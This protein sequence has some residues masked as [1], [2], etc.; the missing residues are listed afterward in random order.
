MRWN[1]RVPVFVFILLTSAFATI[2]AQTGTGRAGEIRG[3]LRKAA[4][5]LKANDTGSAIKELDAVLAV[6]PNNAEAF[7]NLGVIGFYQHDYKKASQYLRKALAT[8]PSLTK[9]QALLGICERRLGE[10]GAQAQLEKSFPTLKDKKLR[11]QVGMELAGIYNQQGN[12]DQTA[13]VM[14]SLVDLDP[15]N[16]EVL[17][18]AQR[19]YSEL[20][21]DTL[22]KLALVA[23]GSARMQ[24]VI[25]ERLINAGDLKNA[26]GHYRK[27]LE[28]DPHLPG[29]HY[30]L[31]QAILAAA[32]N[33]GQPQAEAEKELEAAIRSDGDTAGTECVLARIAAKRSDMDAAYAHYSR[34]F[35]L[36]PGETEAQ[37]GLGR[38]L[39][40]RDQPQEAAKYL[41]MA[42]R[43]D[44]L[45]GEAHYRLASVCRKLQLKDEAAREFKLFQEIKIAKTSLKELYRQMNKNPPAP[46]EP[47]PDAEP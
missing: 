25:A 36:N 35:A 18:M 44:P 23:P 10:P 28:L 42:V 27:A 4:E 43:S 24:Q 40:T 17:Y 20:A 34:A 9:T 21:D 12:L 41:R 46:E 5:H 7:A 37:I 8:D 26:T 30:E 15:D 2:A 14:R 45:N 16:V 32:P 29:I 6:D 47:M 11:I 1:G 38:L 39:I 33:D 31:A 3:H 19:V 13:S 22:N